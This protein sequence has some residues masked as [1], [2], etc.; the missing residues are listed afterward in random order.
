MVVA[1]IQSLPGWT[2]LRLM[3]MSWYRV[4]LLDPGQSLLV[5][6]STLSVWQFSEHCH[7]DAYQELIRHA[8]QILPCGAAYVE[9]VC[10]DVHQQFPQLRVE[11]GI[12]E[13]EVNVVK[14]H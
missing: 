2:V 4:C 10:G 8:N 7:A 9:V 12:G 11:A 1:C 6:R 5:A 3:E 13:G 14:S